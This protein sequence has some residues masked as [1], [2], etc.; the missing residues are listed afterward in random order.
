[1]SMM[2]PEDEANTDA[3]LVPDLRATNC[4]S[5]HTDLET[6]RREIRWIRSRL[7]DLE[8]RLTLEDSR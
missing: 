7:T 3:P 2:H 8:H 4:P 1:M 5:D 6:A